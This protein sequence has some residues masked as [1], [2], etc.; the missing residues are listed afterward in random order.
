M[1][2]IYLDFLTVYFTQLLVYLATCHKSLPESQGFIF[3]S[4]NSMENQLDF[5]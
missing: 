2:F 5:V 4:L 1:V 3:K